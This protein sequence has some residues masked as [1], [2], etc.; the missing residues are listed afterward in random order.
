[1]LFNHYVGCCPPQGRELLRERGGIWTN[2]NRC[3]PPQGRELLRR[4]RGR[5]R[6]D[7]KLLSPAGARTVTL[8]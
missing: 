3:C 1:M 4:N 8:C 5:V 7:I 6:G 2:V